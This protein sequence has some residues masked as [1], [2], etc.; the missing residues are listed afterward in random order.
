MD[1]FFFLWTS[2]HFFQHVVI[3]QI[4]QKYQEEI[5]MQEQSWL[6]LQLQLPQITSYDVSSS[7]AD[8]FK[9]S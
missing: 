5:N 2:I 9:T 3:L 8:T 6:H 1:I 7:T 4:W